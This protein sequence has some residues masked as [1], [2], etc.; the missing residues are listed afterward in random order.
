MLLTCLLIVLVYVAQCLLGCL[1]HLHSSARLPE[2][3]TA[4]AMVVGLT[5]ASLSAHDQGQAQGPTG[6]PGASDST[7]GMQGWGGSSSSSSSADGD[8]SADAGD[9]NVDGLFETG[10]AAGA[11]PTT[12]DD[13]GRCCVICQAS[14]SEA[15]FVLGDKTRQDKSGVG[16]RRLVGG[17]G[18]RM[19][20]I[21]A[22]VFVFAW[23]LVIG[24][25]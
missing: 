16:H 24:Y 2:L 9:G 22:V 6:H 19:S 10:S 4:L 14:S 20:Y 8:G 5:D 25:H 13:R 12:A 18:G 1:W 21:G 11:A 15:L 23:R 7:M 17:V 3:P